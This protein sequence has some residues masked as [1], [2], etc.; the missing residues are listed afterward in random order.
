MADIPFTTFSGQLKQLETNFNSPVMQDFFDLCFSAFKG[1]DRIYSVLKLAGVEWL[2][3]AAGTEYNFGYRPRRFS[4]GTG[5]PPGRYF[6]VC[7]GEDFNDRG[8]LRDEITGY[9]SGE[10]GITPLIFDPKVEP[11]IYELLRSQ[12]FS[13]QSLTYPL[14]LFIYQLERWTE[15]NALLRDNGILTEVGERASITYGV[16]QFSAQLDRIVDLRDPETQAWFADVFVRLE[17]ENEKAAAEETRMS[18]APKQPLAS[19]GELLPVILSLNMGG[20]QIFTQAVGHWLR[21]HGA[22]GL[23]FPSS[24]SNAFNRVQDGRS[25]EWGGWNLVLYKDAEE[26]AP[27]TLFGHMSTWRDPD[28]DHIHVDYMAEGEHRGSFSVRGVREFNLLKFDLEKQ[29]A[30]GVR[31]R[32]IGGELTGGVNEYLSRKVNEIIEK[33]RQGGT[34][35]YQ[36][37]DYIH[38]VH[39]HEELWRKR[40]GQGS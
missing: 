25:V 33:E 38:F 6:T 36:D 26:A 14:Y 30:C 37:V 4:G 29:I 1:L 7:D 9:Y 35:W 32:A 19:F 34:I 31:E 24:R 21:Q 40:Y 12:G 15:E 39:W 28:H 27:L 10:S 11:Y 5:L 13:E 20:G 23:I 2:Q 17:I 3:S 22:N 8:T 18:F 16:R